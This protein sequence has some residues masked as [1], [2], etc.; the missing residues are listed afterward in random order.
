M[1]AFKDRTGQVFG[2]L[3]AL[4]CVQ[5]GRS[6]KWRCRCECGS[7]VTVESGHLRQGNTKSCGC[8]MRET[9]A[10]LTYAHGRASNPSSTYTTWKGMRGRCQNPRSPAWP[11]YGGR[12]IT[13]CERWNDFANFLADMGEKPP[14]LTLERVDNNRGYDPGNCIWADIKTQNGNKR[15]I[16]WVTI[17]GH[18]IRLKDAC[19]MYNVP[20]RPLFSYRSYKGVTITEAFYERLDK[21]LAT[22]GVPNAIDR[23]RIGM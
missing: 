4:E 2:R 22:T 20:H 3:T 5:G 19:V 23:S 13:F 7:I 21:A 8:L 12:G 9:S 6:S 11:Y 1:S 18:R 16:H 17:C 14:G 15:N 10:K